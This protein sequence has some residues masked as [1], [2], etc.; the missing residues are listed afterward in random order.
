MKPLRGS[1]YVNLFAHYRPTGDSEWFLKNNPPGAPEPLLDIGECT[2]INGTA[3]C[4]MNSHK[5]PY[6]SPALE[7][8][9]GPQDL[10]RYWAKVGDHDTDSEEFQLELETMREM[11]RRNIIPAIEDEYADEEF[12]ETDEM[13]GEL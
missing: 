1:F 7:T 12:D 2:R 11:E 4:T 9:R 13:E 8:L 3:K 10:F 6:L 5:V